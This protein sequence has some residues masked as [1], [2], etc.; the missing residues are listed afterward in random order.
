M[1]I[2]YDI[3]TEAREPMHLTEIIRRAKSDFNVEIEPGS[4]VSALTKKVNS[5]RMF[6]RV[7]PS[8]FEILEVSKKTP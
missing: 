5:G 8:T 6:R 4:I 1:G 3:L 7:G 2:V